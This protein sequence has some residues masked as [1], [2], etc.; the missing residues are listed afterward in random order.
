[1]TVATRTT[2]PLISSRLGQV[3]Y[4]LSYW[5]SLLTIGSEIIPSFVCLFH[6]KKVRLVAKGNASN[7]PKCAEDA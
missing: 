6:K 1:M 4:M 3:G 5:C 2:Y 7:C